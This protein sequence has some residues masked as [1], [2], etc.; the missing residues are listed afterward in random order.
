MLNREASAYWIPRWSLSSGGHSAD[1][2]AGNDGLSE[3]RKA[4]YSAGLVVAGGVPDAACAAAAFFSTM[5][6]AMIAPS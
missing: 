2:V 1:P 3:T 5:R 4:P 6:T